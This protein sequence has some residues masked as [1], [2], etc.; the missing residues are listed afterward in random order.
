MSGEVRLD[1]V[2]VAVRDLQAALR[3]LQALGLRCAHVEDVPAEGVRVAF[4]P[5]G[6]AALELLEPTSEA[7][8][9]A[10]FLS[11]RGEGL[12]HVAVRV[13]DLD[14]AL[15][16]AAAAGVQVIPPGPR[17]GARGARVAFL[18]PKTACG[19]LVELVE[20]ARD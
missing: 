15:A 19:V 6:E 7:G 18:H 4:L 9:V 5:A 3:A 11:S 16:R 14:A 20:P 1:H 8:P 17:A 12:H 10:R 13:S 2:A